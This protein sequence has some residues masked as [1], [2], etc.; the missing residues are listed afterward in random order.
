MEHFEERSCK[1]KKK[2]Q[3]KG[4]SF[5][6]PAYPARPSQALLVLNY[7]RDKNVETLEWAVP[8]FCLY[9]HPPVIIMVNFSKQFK[10]LTL[11]S[12]TLGDT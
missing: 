2:E 6:T 10:K 7:G 3:K 8:P 11:L 9:I 5:H 12:R 4:Q 1:K